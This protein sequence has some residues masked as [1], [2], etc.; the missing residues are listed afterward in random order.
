MADFDS[1]NRP[2]KKP[3]GKDPA[4]PRPCLDD[5]ARHI[6][7]GAERDDLRLPDEQ[8]RLLLQIAAEVRLRMRAGKE[9][10]HF[11]QSGHGLGISVLFTGA[12]GS[13]KT[14]AA[15]VLAREL[16]LD[17]YRVDLSAVFSKYIGETEK[18]LDRL[19]AA[20]A[21]SGAIL[22]FDEA[23]EL[24]GKRSDVS[25]S[26][27]R[28]ANL[29]INYLLQRLENYEGLAVLAT[30][31]RTHIDPAFLRRFRFVVTFPRPTAAG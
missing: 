27:D 29:D 6:I 23:D 3:T 2:K 25:D 5:L 11:A 4:N 21:D 15:A 18:N 31:F 19:F 7:T 24:F 26:H 28:Y 8:Q 17:L 10:E 20:A 30:N 13:G 14:M 9:M 1:L 16:Q 22:L 12:G